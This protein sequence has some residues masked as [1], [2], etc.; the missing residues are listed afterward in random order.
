MIK[1]FESFVFGDSVNDYK[2]LKEEMDEDEDEYDEDEYDEDDDEDEYDDDEDEYEDEDDD[3]DD[4]NF[5]DNNNHDNNV[6]IEESRIKQTIS[7][8]RHRRFG[9]KLNQKEENI[10]KSEF[11]TFYKNYMDDYSIGDRSSYK[12]IH[13]EIFQDDGYYYLTLF[14]DKYYY[15]KLDGFSALI[16]AIKKW[17]EKIK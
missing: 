3:F 5:D 8:L 12:V 14:S 9:R 16:G 17:E 4:V 15:F 11:D 13:L 7:D 2:F 1:R 6:S 10:L